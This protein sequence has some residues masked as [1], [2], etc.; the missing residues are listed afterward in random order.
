MSLSIAMRRRW[1]NRA[2]T[3]ALN[4]YRGIPF[5]TRPPVGRI[6]VPT[7]YIW[8][9]HDVA[10]AR[11]AAELTANYVAGR[12]RLSSWTPVTGYPKPNLMW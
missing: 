10:L 1:P 5:S 4:W 11:A 8:G 3:G 7:T 12:M 9:R 2:L 6:T